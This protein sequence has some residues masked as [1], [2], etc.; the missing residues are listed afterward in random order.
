MEKLEDLIEKKCGPWYE[1]HK[2][3][4]PLYIP[5]GLVAWYFYGMLLNSLKL[6]RQATFHIPGQEVPSIWVV[7]PFK[8]WFVV[9]PLPGAPMHSRLL[10]SPGIIR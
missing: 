7:N 9:F 3:K 6:G 10:L 2:A 1:R 8:N 5:M 4:F